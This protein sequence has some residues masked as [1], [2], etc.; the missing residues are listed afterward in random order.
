MP[1]ARVSRLARG[2]RCGALADARALVA[3]HQMAVRQPL[4]EVSDRAH[5]RQQRGLVLLRARD[6]RAQLL[7]RRVVRPACGP[8]LAQASRQQEEIGLT[9][10]GHRREGRAQ[11]ALEVR[12]PCAAQQAR[13][14]RKQR[15]A[16]RCKVGRR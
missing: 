9:R 5:C 15:D 10:V 7:R 4:V 13:R 3:D 1:Q 12:L 16:E 8:V 2:D 6:A 11:L 14:K